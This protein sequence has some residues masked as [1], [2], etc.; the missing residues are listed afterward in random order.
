MTISK[1][2]VYWFVDA[3]EGAAVFLRNGR[4]YISMAIY[5]NLLQ[6]GPDIR[7]LKMNGT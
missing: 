1:S 7:Y 3:P 5:G 4:S 2:K 6:P